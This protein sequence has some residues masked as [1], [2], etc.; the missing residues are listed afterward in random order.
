M[1]VSVS[2]LWGSDLLPSLLGQIVS[3]LWLKV[4]AEAITLIVGRPIFLAMVARRI[5][6]LTTFPTIM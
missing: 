5:F 2:V 4:V 6:A 3:K 1:V